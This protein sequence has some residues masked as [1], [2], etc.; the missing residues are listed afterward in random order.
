MSTAWIESSAPHLNAPR[1]TVPAWKS[2]LATGAVVAASG[3]LG[4]ACHALGLATTNIAM[5][6]LAG[7]VIVAARFGRGPAIAAAVLGALVFDFFFVAPLFAF[8]RS[9]TQYLVTLVVMLGIGVVISELTARLQTQLRAA[10]DHER[11]TAELFRASQRQERRT[12]QLYRMTRQLSE[13]AGTEFL[14]P[15][16]GRQLNEIFDAEIVLLLSNATSD[17]LQLRFGLDTS[18]AANPANLAVRRWVAENHCTAGLG[19]EHLLEATA[20]LIPLIG[21][22]RTVGVL[23]VGRTIPHAVSTA[24]IAACSKPAPA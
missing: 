24:K 9:D 23:G 6:F 22:Q 19:T 1:N 15:R 3:L 17:E 7:V 14:V 5:I 8:D 21:S 13:L 20:L 12:A 10:Q 18:I 4:W 16:A 2:Y 11:Q